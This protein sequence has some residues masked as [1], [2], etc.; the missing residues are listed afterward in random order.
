MATEDQLGERTVALV[1]DVFML[2]ILRELKDASAHA[3]DIHKRTRGVSLAGVRGRLRKLARN[4][5]VSALDETGRR[6]PADARAP[7]NA[8]YKLT[9]IVGNAA[10]EMIDECER[11]ERRWFTSAQLGEPGML[12]LGLSADSALRAIVRALADGPLR[13]TELEARVPEV[14]HAVLFRRL[15][16]LTTQRLLIREGHGRN[17]SY[18]LSDA[19]REL[20]TVP[21]H[22][23]HCETVRATSTDRS[24]PADLWGL[25]HVVA[26]LVE[27]PAEIT[28]TFCVHVES[29]RIDDVYLHAAAGR[30]TALAVPPVG[31]P[32]AIVRASTLAWCDILFGGDAALN[33]TGADPAVVSAIFLAL[34]KVLHPSGSASMDE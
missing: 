21:L 17:V 16:E 19:V 24:L 26:P 5:L 33:A 28:G 34:S 23:A 15:P 20:V 6:M 3:K 13:A 31:E 10:L 30:I 11:W 18:E 22:A 4:Q 14:K 32:Q 27:I 7:R 29:P 8:L 2:A 1:H 12:A 25:L 9:E